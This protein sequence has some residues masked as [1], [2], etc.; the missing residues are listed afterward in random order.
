MNLYIKA[1]TLLTSVISI[2]SIVF[3]C[4]SVSYKKVDSEVTSQKQWQGSRQTLNPKLDSS[5]IYLHKFRT[6]YLTPK[7]KINKNTN[8]NRFGIKISDKLACGMTALARETL[9]RKRNSLKQ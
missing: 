4:E 3:A 5:D 8:Q 9:R 2:P 6:K 1:I 7:E